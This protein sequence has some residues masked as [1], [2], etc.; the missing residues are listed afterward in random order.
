MPTKIEINGPLYPYT[1]NDSRLIADAVKQAGTDAELDVHWHSPGGSIWEGKKL[2]QLFLDHEGPVNMYVT[3]AASAAS[4]AAMSGDKLFV[5]DYSEWMVHSAMTWFSFF[6]NAKELE[7]NIPV[8]QKEIK[9]LRSEDKVLAKIYADRSKIDLDEMTGYMDEETTWYGKDILD[10]GFATDLLETPK[11]EGGSKENLAKFDLS[12]FEM[13][14]K[15]AFHE[16]YG[17]GI[18]PAFAWQAQSNAVPENEPSPEPEK[19][20]KVAAAQAK[21]RQRQLEIRKMRSPSA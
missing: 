17:E 15:S 4:Y 20:R 18:E 10:V 5:Y 1:D 13:H 14:R 7:G 3:L 12:C 11:R 9:N 8:W 21:A 19:L 6:G 16:M 2:F